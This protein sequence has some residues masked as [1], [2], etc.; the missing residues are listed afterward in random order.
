MATDAADL[1]AEVE[2]SGIDEAEVVPPPST[3][4]KIDPDEFFSKNASGR[5]PN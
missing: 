3:P 5:L 1:T 4:T 2:V